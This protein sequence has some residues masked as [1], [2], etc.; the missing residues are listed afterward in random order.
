MTFLKHL[1]IMKERSSIQRKF[2]PEKINLLYNKNTGL[3]KNDD[4]I[5]R[6]FYLKFLKYVYNNFQ[7]YLISL[8]PTCFP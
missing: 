2:V 5:C 8:M 7:W 6:N 3:P 4:Y 1:H